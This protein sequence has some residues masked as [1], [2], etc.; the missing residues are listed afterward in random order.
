MGVGMGWLHPHPY[1]AG[2]IPNQRQERINNVTKI[3]CPV[4][5]QGKELSTRDMKLL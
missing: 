1:P 2:A 5:T 4:D 3:K